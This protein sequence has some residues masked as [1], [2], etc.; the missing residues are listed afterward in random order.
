MTGNEFAA[1]GRTN[2]SVT[3][4]SPRLRALTPDPTAAT[5]PEG[6]TPS[7][8]GSF[9]G[10]AYAPASTTRSSVRSSDP[11]Q[12]ARTSRGL[13]GRPLIEEHPVDTELTDRCGKGREVYR[14]AHVAV[15][16]ELVASQHVFILARGRENDDGDGFRASIGA[17][18]LEH[19]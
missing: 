19:V 13:S 10:T 6:S 15:R 17:H 1:G 12:H 4:R 16:S 8:C 14:L 9:T 11:P 18:A 3:T 5:T 7:T 2:C